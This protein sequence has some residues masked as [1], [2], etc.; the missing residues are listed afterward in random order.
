MPAWWHTRTHTEEGG[1][2]SRRC[3][4]STLRS[5]IAI[6]N[7]LVPSTRTRVT[8]DEISAETDAEALPHRTLEAR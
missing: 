5:Q 1:V 8:P 3:D 2:V 7:E 6:R 4:G